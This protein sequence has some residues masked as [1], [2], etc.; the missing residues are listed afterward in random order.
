MGSRPAAVAFQTARLIFWPLPERSNCILDGSSCSS[1]PSAFGPDHPDRLSAAGFSRHGRPQRRPRTLGMMGGQGANFLFNGGPNIAT[2]SHACA[3][4]RERAG[5]PTFWATL[6]ATSID[7]EAADMI[8]I[9]S[10]CALARV[11]VLQPPRGTLTPDEGDRRAAL[12]RAN[13]HPGGRPPD[14]VNMF[15]RTRLG[16]ARTWERP[17]ARPLTQPK[18]WTI[19]EEGQGDLY[20]SGCA[21]TC[22][23]ASARNSRRSVGLQLQR[24]KDSPDQGAVC[25][26]CGPNIPKELG[27]AAPIPYTVE[28]ETES[29]SP[30]CC[31]NSHVHQVIHKQGKGVGGA[32][33]RGLNGTGRRTAPE[34]WCFESWEAAYRDRAENAT[35]AYKW[36]PSMFQ[37]QRGPVEVEKGLVHQKSC[38]R[39]PSRRGPP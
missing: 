24:L 19:S 23:S 20:L 1:N 3:I 38:P 13:A 26:A 33:A 17:H 2:I 5:P 21:T 15:S 27:R 11:C 7:S 32:W 30:R 12:R 37:K 6:F 22:P 31:C 29:R 10:G 16:G 34:P 28:Y 35:P 39:I 9:S 14:I 36:G 25:L 18:S 8:Q 4:L